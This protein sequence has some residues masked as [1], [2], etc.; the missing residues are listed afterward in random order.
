[1]V[2]SKRFRYKTVYRN[3]QFTFVTGFI[4]FCTDAF[5]HRQHFFDVNVFFT[6]QTNHIVKL[7]IFHAGSSS[8][9]HG[10]VNVLFRNPL[11]NTFTHTCTAR[12]GGY[13]HST[14]SAYRK[15]LRHLLIQSICT[16]GRYRKTYTLAYQFRS[17]LFNLRMIGHS[18]SHQA[19][20]FGTFRTFSNICQNIFQRTRARL[21]KAVTCHTKTT[22]TTTAT[23]NFHDVHI[24]KFR[25]TCHNG[26]SMRISINIFYPLTRNFCRYTFIVSHTYKF[27]VFIVLRSIVFRHV[28]TG[29]VCQIQK[30]FFLSGVSVDGIQNLLDGF[31]TFANNESICHRSQRFRVKSSTRTANNDKGFFFVAHFC[32]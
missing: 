27:I 20:L 4:H 7:N 26:R 17:K 10:I 2:R 12:F 8:Q 28:N 22:V 16:Q 13:G 6:W 23:S 19:N 14:L 18:S 25:T 5:N 3:Y 9:F 15:S 21:S 32:T 31:F 30:L 11:V 1:M 24:F 29:K